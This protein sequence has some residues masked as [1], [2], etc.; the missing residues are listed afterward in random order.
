MIVTVWNL[1]IAGGGIVGGLILGG[2]GSAALVWSLLPLLVISFFIAR[3]TDAFD[4]R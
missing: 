3:S 2:L 4:P 1:A